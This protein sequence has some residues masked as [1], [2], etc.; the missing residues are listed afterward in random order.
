MD[1]RWHYIAAIV[2][3]QLAFL[4]TFTIPIIVKELIDSLFVAEPVP[5]SGVLGYFV[6]CR[7]PFFPGRKPGT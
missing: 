7:T 3:S 1:Y 6:V 2:F 5:F 4:S